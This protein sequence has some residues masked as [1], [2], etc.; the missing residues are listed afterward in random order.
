MKLGITIGKWY[1][2]YIPWFPHIGIPINIS[3]NTIKWR[4]NAKVNNVSSNTR[5]R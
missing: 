2:E 1:S 5:S 3:K 4:N